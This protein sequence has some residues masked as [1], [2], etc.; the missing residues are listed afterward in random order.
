MNIEEFWVFFNKNSEFFNKMA[1]FSDIKIDFKKELFY[2]NEMWY[3]DPFFLILL[4][5]RDKFDEMGPSSDSEFTRINRTLYNSGI[6]VPFT[7][8]E[9]DLY[10]N[11]DN[12]NQSILSLLES[13]IGA[14]DGKFTIPTKEFANKMFRNVSSD[15][16]MVLSGLFIYEGRH[17]RYY[18]DI[19]DR[20]TG[21]EV[22]LDNDSI[23]IPVKLYEIDRSAFGE[24]SLRKISTNEKIILK[25]MLNVEPLDSS[26]AYISEEYTDS[27]KNIARYFR[28]FN[29]SS[30][31]EMF[32]LELTES[33]YK[34]SKDDPVITVNNEIITTYIASKMIDKYL[35]SGSSSI[36][37]LTDMA[38]IASS[39][40]KIHKGILIDNISRD[41]GGEVIELIK[42]YLEGSNDNFI[43]KISEMTIRG[44]I[45]FLARIIRLNGD[46]SSIRFFNRKMRYYK[47]F[48]VDGKG[49]SNELIPELGGFRY[50]AS[51]CG[52][53][54]EKLPSGFATVESFIT[55][56][57]LKV[58][59]SEFGS[60]P[61]FD[62]FY[63]SGVHRL[64][65]RVVFN[66]IDGVYGL[67]NKHGFGGVL[68]E[69]SDID[70]HVPKIKASKN[71]A[72]T[73][74]ETL[75]DSFAGFVSGSE[76][77]HVLAAL[78]TASSLSVPL[79]KNANKPVM[80]I[81]GGG[82]YLKDGAKKKIFKGVFRNSNVI[83]TDSYFVIKT[84]AD[85]S[86][87]ILVTDLDSSVRNTLEKLATERFGTETV[88]RFRNTENLV[89]KTNTAP[90]CV[91]A[92]EMWLID[93][94]IVFN[95]PAR[96]SSEAGAFLYEEDDVSGIIVS[97]ILANQKRLL[98]IEE[99]YVEKVKKILKKKKMTSKHPYVDFFEKVL[100]AMCLSEL[101]GYMNGW[102]F[103]D[104]MYAVYFNDENIKYSVNF[105]KLILS[106][107]NGSSK[108][109]D[110]LYDENLRL[111]QNGDIVAVD[112]IFHM[113]YIDKKDTDMYILLF[114]KRKVHKRLK[115]DINI[116]YVEFAQA[117]ESMKDYIGIENAMK[118][119]RLGHDKSKNIYNWYLELFSD[120]K[121]NFGAIK[122]NKKNVYGL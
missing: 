41:I 102:E 111:N 100:G 20:I 90:I 58:A 23:F 28:I 119:Y 3:A 9:Y 68:L 88:T 87:S 110:K 25:D 85:G 89:T 36:A 95:F 92:D 108:I 107:S 57:I 118:N 59:Q 18:V 15:M 27:I 6:K 109:E 51:Y 97:Y 73:A 29:I 42:P 66:S 99:K 69:S 49:V 56:A 11:L 46:P 52:I 5:F 40:T 75:V 79:M 94:S 61:V 83:N 63:S 80:A 77:R 98:Q 48:N 24:D 116:G 32:I 106:L 115:S 114:D 82:P 39:M 34:F 113:S 30:T 16:E 26:T 103:H 60:L 4:L 43:G 45:E 8:K 101:I 76:D 55:Y 35:T 50:I 78:L 13:F 37:E 81:Y 105:E 7:K 93:E 120:N 53:T 91:F 117:I 38:R 84:I 121:D 33:I 104:K 21:F 62:R 10:V 47:D 14:E 67:D 44:N 96:A 12:K 65:D 31:N 74:I 22:F 1:T 17:A 64:F 71:S 70:F 2:K 86:S 122:I 54:A 19:Y 112:K 72:C